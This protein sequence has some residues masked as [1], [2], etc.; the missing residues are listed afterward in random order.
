MEARAPI[1]RTKIVKSTNRRLTN[2]EVCRILR[3]LARPDSPSLRVLAAEFH[4]SHHVIWCIAM[5][6]TYKEVRC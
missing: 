6:T 2:E 4:V 1:K 5:G 3:R